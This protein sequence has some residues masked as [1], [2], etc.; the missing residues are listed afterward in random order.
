MQAWPRKISRYRVAYLLLV[1]GILVHGIP[2]AIM[3]GTLLHEYRNGTGDCILHRLDDKDLD[4][5]MFKA[6]IP[7]V[8]DMN[9]ELEEKFGWTIGFKDVAKGYLQVLPFGDDRKNKG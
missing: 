5:A 2:V 8:L 4:V 6:H 1:V 3:C 7:L 9:K